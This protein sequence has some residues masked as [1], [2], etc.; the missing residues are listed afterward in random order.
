M[1]SSRLESATV[2]THKPHEDKS[3]SEPKPERTPV[4][5][6]QTKPSSTKTGNK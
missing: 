6:S 5:N 2:D 4:L 1:S 3:N